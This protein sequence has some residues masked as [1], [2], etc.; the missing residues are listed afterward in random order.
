MMHLTMEIGTVFS[1]HL[2]ILTGRGSKKTH[3]RKTP[4]RPIL[5]SSIPSEDEDNASGLE[6]RRGYVGGD[7]PEDGNL[8][9]F[10]RSGSSDR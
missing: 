5:E 4:K 9:R 10:L 2:L 3:P 6:N 1:C 7:A 8:V